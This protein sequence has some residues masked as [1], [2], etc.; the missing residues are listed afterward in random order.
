[1]S[2]YYPAIAGKRSMRDW[3]VGFWFAIGAFLFRYKRFNK[4]ENDGLNLAGIM[5]LGVAIFPLQTNG[6][7]CS[8]IT[9]HKRSAVSFFYV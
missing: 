7:D 2:D 8:G 3:Y 4:K 6:G 5:A 1:M 9:M